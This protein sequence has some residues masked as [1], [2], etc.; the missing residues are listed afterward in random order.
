[1]YKNVK[2]IIL[3]KKTLSRN[4]S[5]LYY[6]SWWKAK[7]LNGWSDSTIEILSDSWSVVAVNCTP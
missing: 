4:L 5:Y 6:C 3:L 2:L 7:E 1:M